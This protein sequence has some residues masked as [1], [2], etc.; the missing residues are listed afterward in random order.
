MQPP[1]KTYTLAEAQL[2]LENYCTYQDRCHREVR[3]KLK[4]MHMIPAACDQIMIH[5]MQENYLNEERF[6][7]S[8]ARGKF[9]G[10]KWGKARIIKELRFR[11]VSKPNINIALTEINDEDYRETFE[12]LVIKRLNQIKYEKDKYK[13]RKKL[14]DYLAYRGWPMD[15]IYERAKELI[16]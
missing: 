1:I 7:R 4:D 2:K 12:N 9:K 3:Q 5:L 13:K 10:K 15:W 11:G 6:A 16:P 14:A 8:F